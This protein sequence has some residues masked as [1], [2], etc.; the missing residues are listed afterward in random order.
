MS[1]ELSPRD[2]IDWPEPSDPPALGPSDVHVWAASLEAD[3]STWAIFLSPS[4]QERAARFHFE[5]HRRRF[6]V[7]RGLLRVILGRYLQAR[8]QSVEFVCSAHGKPEL[9]G[10]F[11]S[12]GLRFNL[13][14]SEDLAVLAV[15]RLGPVGVD[16]EKILPLEDA[17]DLVARF[18]SSRENAS[19]Q[20]LPNEQKAKAFFSLWTRKEAWL[21]ATGEGIAHSLNLV[22]VSFLPDEPAKL[23]SLPQHLS[24][25]LG[26]SLHSLYPA[27]QFAAALAVASESINLH[28][29]RWNHHNGQGDSGNKAL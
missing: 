5:L 4:E 17:D 26:W 11:T 28:C 9:S 25:G 1:R 20:Q 16:L 24:Q 3:A 15:T 19:F 12:N 21:K 2:T 22:E 18:F 14:H 7:G 6:I 13:A 8:P 27:E 10:P 23:L 29:W